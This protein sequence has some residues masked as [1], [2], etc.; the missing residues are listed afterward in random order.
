M[1][2]V[3]IMFKDIVGYEGK[4]IICSDGTVWSCKSKKFLK[5]RYTKTGYARVHLGYNTDYYIH[6]LVAEAFIPNP[7]NY[8]CI[9]HK[10]ENKKNNNIKY[11]KNNDFLLNHQI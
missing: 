10:D 1:G 7:H 9:N 11:Q 3:S 6:K 8:K 5:P 2:N 4:Y